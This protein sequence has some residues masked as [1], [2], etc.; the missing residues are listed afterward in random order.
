[1]GFKSFRTRG[2][3]VGTSYFQGRCWLVKALPGPVLKSLTGIVG[4]Q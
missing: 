1:M 3:A 2:Y 4:E